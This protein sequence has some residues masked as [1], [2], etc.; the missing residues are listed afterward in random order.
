[1]KILNKLNEDGAIQYSAHV[2]IGWDSDNSE[3][4][5]FCGLV[6]RVKL[7]GVVVGGYGSASVE[8]R[9]LSHHDKEQEF[10]LHAKLLEAALT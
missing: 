1:V 9:L 6:P 4:A 5:Y 10:T 2:D 7:T 8:F 3:D